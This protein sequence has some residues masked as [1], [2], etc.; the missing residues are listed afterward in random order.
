MVS[1]INKINEI[2]AKI[3]YAILTPMFALMIT[4]MVIQ[5]ICRYFIKSPL[6]WSEET[7]RY[8]FIACTFMGGAIAAKERTH[9][10]INFI[11]ALI[12][13]IGKNNRK[14]R[15]ITYRIGNYIRDAVTIFFMCFVC[16]TTL[17]L[18]MDQAFYNMPSPAMQFPLWIVTSSMFVG[19]LLVVVHSVLLIIL[20]SCGTGITGYEEIDVELGGDGRCI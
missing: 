8:L 3:E 16:Y 4:L 2:L 10:E 13:K 12:K 14:A 15:L 18:V 20:N 19:S 17:E 11:E 1:V 9:I 6:A 5:V 7:T